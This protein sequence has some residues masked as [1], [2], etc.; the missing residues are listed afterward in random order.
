M[1]KNLTF[2]EFLYKKKAFIW[3]I[4]EFSN[5]ETLLTLNYK[6]I[7]IKMIFKFLPEGAEKLWMSKKYNSD[8]NTL[9][10]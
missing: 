2:G 1:D 7:K 9:G 3:N 5:G 10:W 6:N 8:D 4:L